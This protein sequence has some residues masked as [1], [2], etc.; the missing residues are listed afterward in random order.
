MSTNAARQI[1]FDGH[2]ELA[3]ARMAQPDTGVPGRQ[4]AGVLTRRRA[5]QGAGIALATFGLL[6]V[7]ERDAGIAR[8]SAA[9]VLTSEAQQKAKPIIVLTHG[10]W[11]DGSGWR[12]VIAGLHA[13]GYSVVAPP[14]GLGSLSADI[15]AVRKVITD[16]QAPVLLVGHSYGGAVVTGAASGLAAVKG[17]VYLS[18][19]APD[20][21]ESLLSLSTRFGQQY[22]ATPSASYLLPDG[23]PDNPQT[24]IY[25]DR[26]H[27]G[28][29]FVQDIAPARAA[30]LAAVQR[31]LAVGAFVEPLQVAPA[32]RQI[33]TWYQ[34]S[35]ADR[36]IQPE[37]ERWM[38]QRMGAE[39]IELDASHLALFSR[40]QPIVKL[41]EKAAR[42]VV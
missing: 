33:R 9:G 2:V 40:P 12:K 39:T 38:A 8:A 11:A 14:V 4:P 23:A 13:D 27:F 6:G 3:D 7:T 28:E 16:L 31:P 17:L 29:V 22:G 37:A 35:T 32:W 34:V 24:L 20:T 5:L 41:I 1:S 21:G 30:V 36:S 25:L 19:F 15:A 18:A 10:A 42:A 26:A